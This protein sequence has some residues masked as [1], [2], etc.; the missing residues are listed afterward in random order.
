MDPTNQP[1]QDAERR[2]RELQA[3]VETGRHRIAHTKRLA[4]ELRF[5]M[6]SSEVIRPSQLPLLD[7]AVKGI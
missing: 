1:I 7:G 3:S 4:L 6:A 2:L 5:A